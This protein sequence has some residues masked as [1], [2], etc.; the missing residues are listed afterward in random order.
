MLQRTTAACTEGSAARLDARRRCFEHLEQFGFVKIPPTFA[1]NKTYFLSLQRAC[2]KHFLARYCRNT[3][4]IVRDAFN[5]R[6]FRLS[7]L[8]RHRLLRRW[9]GSSELIQV[10]LIHLRKRRAND[11]KLTFQTF[12]IQISA[13]VLKPQ[14]DEIRDSILAS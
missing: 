7:P 2:Y 3:A 4:T 9:P 14:I 10:R 5:R 8:S 12:V 11:T 6:S 1:A 13:H